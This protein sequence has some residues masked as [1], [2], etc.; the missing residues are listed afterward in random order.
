M[1]QKSKWTKRNWNIY[2]KSFYFYESHMKLCSLHVYYMYV[3]KTVYAIIEYVSEYVDK[4]SEEPTRQNLGSPN[5]CI[6]TLNRIGCI[7]CVQ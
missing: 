3:H 5:I 1:L 4:L 7:C 6:L 2:V